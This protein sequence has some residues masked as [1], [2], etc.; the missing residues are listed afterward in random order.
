MTNYDR[1][2]HGIHNLE[3][4]EVIAD[5]RGYVEAIGELGPLFFD[6]VG[7]LWVCSGYREAAQILSDFKNFSSA[8]GRQRGE[9]AERGL[10]PGAEL[11]A[12]VGEQMLFV[13]PPSHSEL[14]A[15]LREQFTVAK[16]R[17]RD[18]DVRDLVGAI[19]DR[20]PGEGEIDLVGDLAG[21][22]PS[23]L[24]AYLLGMPGR[25]LELGRWADGYERLLG[26][27]S[28]LPDVRD[29]EVVPILREAMAAFTDQAR[30]RLAQPADDLIGAL[31][32]P[33]AGL[34]DEA[35]LER[36]LHIIAANC[37]VLVGGGYQTLTQLVAGGLLLLEQHP[38]QLRALRERPELID[39]AIDEFMRLNGS[40]QYVARQVTAD[41][42]LA[43]MTLRAGQSVLVHLGAANLDPAVYENPHQ[44]D[45]TRR[46]PRHL[47]FGLGRHYCA[48]APYAQQAA[49]WA[50]LG[51]LDRYPHYETAPG[52]DAVVWGKHANTRAPARVRIRVSAGRPEAPAGKPAASTV[53]TVDIRALLERFN[54][55]E[56]ALGEHRCWHQLFERWARITPNAIA[57]R[58]SDGEYGYAELD[59]RANALARTLRAS[60]VQP[61]SVV[62]VVMERS[63]D[64]V[65]SVLAVAKAG[66]AFLLA[67]ADSPTERMRHM[68]HDASAELVLA[69]ERTAARLRDAGLTTTVLIPGTTGR[70][71]VPPVT[72]TTGGNTA[73]AVFTS[74]TTGQ[75]KGIVIDHLG[76]VNLHLA[77]RR[78]LRITP[79]DRVLQFLSPSFDG[80]VFDLVLALTA[81]ATL[82]V[83]RGPELTV[84][85]PLIRLLRERGVTAANLTPSVWA[86]LPDAELPDL[87]LA[88]AA[89]ERLPAATITRWHR[90][91]R[92]FCNLYGPAETAV[93]ATWHDC[94]PGEAPPIGSPVTNKR[95][96]VLDEDLRPVGIGVPGE[97]CVSGLGV[98]RYLSRP[99][100]METKFAPDPFGRPG[101][102]LYRTGDIGQWLP[103]GSLEFLGRRDRQV[104]IRGQRVEL[105]EIERTLSLAPGVAENVVIAANGALE[106]LVVPAGTELDEQAVR[107]YLSARLH[108]GMVPAK[109]TVVEELPRTDTGKRR[110]DQAAAAAAPP[111][112]RP[113]SGTGQ[114]IATDFAGA[115][116]R[117]V[118]LFADCLRVPATQV[119]A[120]SDFFAEGGDSLA[121][122]A[123]LTAIEQEFGTRIDVERLLDDPSPIGV[124]R[125]V[126]GAPPRLARTAR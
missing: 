19:L 57:V 11:A 7:Q 81:G 50:I 25:Q 44:L 120:E 111:V 91:G 97:I 52:P 14:R 22:V 46:G 125:A 45:I 106:A 4:P 90:P 65:I 21:P 70:A 67:A 30:A 72:G 62:A 71:P 13:D 18:E 99:E 80:C 82:E 53:D 34:D 87:R 117:L 95:V 110:L 84:G 124:A 2:R 64:F 28:S 38:E 118:R 27:L 105:D 96:Y 47:G 86:A 23:A 48:G 56:V 60:N 75:P 43:G 6:E 115:L 9:L 103:S 121:L 114:A 123:L 66:G 68:L 61:E 54:D 1:R 58:D 24:V 49:R 15:P 78:I 74:G 63:V 37:V 69:D 5:P 55:N 104:K 109:F 89:G 42:E 100:L 107:E 83:A 17:E 31:A 59:E 40:S 3:R 29:G 79:A 73:Y 108:T 8:R 39:S 12:M 85:P 94:V 16:V 98:G 20:L 92:R 35:E 119:R 122:S 10:G 93:W 88:M 41:V 76:V 26:S 102:L 101:E 77:Q 51:F 112:T 33:L 36:R 32:G 126:T 116:D 113:E